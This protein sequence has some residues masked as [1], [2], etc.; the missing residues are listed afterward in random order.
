MKKG[1]IFASG[2]LTGIGLTAVGKWL[3]VNH[4]V[5][6][7]ASDV[8]DITEELYDESTPSEEET[9]SSD[10][11]SFS[12]PKLVRSIVIRDVST[13]SSTYCN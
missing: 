1:L 4:N 13:A 6:N 3:I 7:I 2:V 12:V 9:T 5:K 8:L 10:E 11:K